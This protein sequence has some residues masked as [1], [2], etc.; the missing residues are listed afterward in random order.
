MSRICCVALASVLLLGRASAAPGSDSL[1][2]VGDPL[3][4]KSDSLGA[5]GGLIEFVP[6]HESAGGWTRLVG[7]R[8]FL[9]SRQ[10]AADAADALARQARQR[11]PAAAVTT[12]GRRT[13]SIV[14]FSLVTP[15]GTIEYNVF[16]YAVGP[17]GRGLVSLQYARRLRG[18][19]TD[20]MTVQA[21]RWAAE[22]ARF[23]MN[24]VR[25]AFTQPR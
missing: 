18:S 22:I 25:A 10:S 2:F 14:E 12:Y 9:D 4:A 5:Q 8:A 3:V 24:R 20:T 17:G 23:D 1:T 6:P 16:R 19:D 13:E 7:Y 15:D 11:Y 21:P